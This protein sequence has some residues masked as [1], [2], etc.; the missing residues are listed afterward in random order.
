MS[1]DHY[2]TDCNLFLSMKIPPERL[3]LLI[4]HELDQNHS[5]QVHKKLRSVFIITTNRNETAID[6][7]YINYW[8]DH[9]EEVET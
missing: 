8:E 1:L 2:Q 6:S 7:S 9:S 3:L 4:G 5:Q